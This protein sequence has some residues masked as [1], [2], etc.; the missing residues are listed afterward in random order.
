MVVMVEL[1]EVAMVR[2]L[3]VYVEK[4]TL[5]TM[6]RTMVDMNSLGSDGATALGSSIYTQGGYNCW[7]RLDTNS[8]SQ[9]RYF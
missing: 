7:F 6:L 9:Y 5:I 4:M 8:I 2:Q 1:V 3:V